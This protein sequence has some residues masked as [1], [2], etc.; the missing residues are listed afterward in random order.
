MTSAPLYSHSRTVID[1]DIDEVCVALT[2]LSKGVIVDP[3]VIDDPE[4][5]G[6]FVN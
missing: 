4:S 6:E 3:V 5:T 1:V 2:A